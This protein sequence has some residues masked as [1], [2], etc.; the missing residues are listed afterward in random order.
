MLTLHNGLL[1]REHHRNARF[2]LQAQSSTSSRTQIHV[3][4]TIQQG[5]SEFKNKNLF[6][7]KSNYN[8]GRK[9]HFLG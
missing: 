3:P 1:C 5:T 6:I 9:Q 4:N 8:N 7:E 2:Y